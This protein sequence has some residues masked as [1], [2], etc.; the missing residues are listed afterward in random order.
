MYLN[1]GDLVK[2]TRPWNDQ[3]L[4]GVIVSAETEKY[5]KCVF[6]VHWINSGANKFTSK[7]VFNTWEV[8]GSLRRVKNE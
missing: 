8:E 3:T 1:V 5:N 2:G 7:P 4:V 6:E